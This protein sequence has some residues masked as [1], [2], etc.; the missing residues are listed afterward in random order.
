MTKH[1]GK[2]DIIEKCLCF[3][4]DV[5]DRQYFADLL[6]AALRVGGETT[7]RNSL[8]DMRSPEEKDAVIDHFYRMFK[9]RAAA[10]DPETYKSEMICSRL[11]ARKC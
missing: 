2:V 8:S 1:G 4:E 9:Q 7:F 6:I 11:I 3:A 5:D 10:K